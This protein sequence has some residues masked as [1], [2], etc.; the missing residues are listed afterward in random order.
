MQVHLLGIPKL[1]QLPLFLTECGVFSEN[2]CVC[3]RAGTGGGGQT[4]LEKVSI[5]GRVNLYM[6]FHTTF[7]TIPNSRLFSPYCAIC[8]VL[9]FTFL[10]LF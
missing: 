1:I 8:S 5:I 10:S 4:D 6:C 3:V 7:F 9:A 2:V